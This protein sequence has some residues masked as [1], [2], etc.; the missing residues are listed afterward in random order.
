MTKHTPGPW[1][2]TSSSEEGTVH[3]ANGQVIVPHG[4]NSPAK[5]ANAQLI[6]AAPAMLEALEEIRR[7]VHLWVRADNMAGR[8][9]SIARETIDLARGESTISDKGHVV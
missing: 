5:M 2:S 9:D 4:D 7:N 8:L 1:Y 6:A 3:A